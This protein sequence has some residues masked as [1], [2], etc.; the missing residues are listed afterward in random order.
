MNVASQ[1]AHT[2][3]SGSGHFKTL[4]GNP[5]ASPGFDYESMEIIRKLFGQVGPK[6]WGS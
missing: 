2:P 4:P 1:P 3:S 5:V 6:M